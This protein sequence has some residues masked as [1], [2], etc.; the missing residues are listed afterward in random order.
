MLKKKNSHSPAT[1]KIVTK[2]KKKYSR[3]LKQIQINIRSFIFLYNLLFHDTESVHPF[4]NLCTFHL[5]RRD[6][7]LNREK[8]KYEIKIDCINGS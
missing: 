4:S 6:E 2:K 1:A 7:N 3:L 5:D 8:N